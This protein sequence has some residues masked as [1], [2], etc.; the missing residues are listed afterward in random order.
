LSKIYQDVVSPDVVGHDPGV[1]IQQR[2]Q[3][4]VY[5][6]GCIEILEMVFQREVMPPL[7][8]NKM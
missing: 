7:I 2:K 1:V 8:P 5:R 6:T 4:P 3:R